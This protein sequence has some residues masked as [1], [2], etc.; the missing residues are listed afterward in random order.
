M[1]IQTNIDPMV[2][3]IYQGIGSGGGK[4][5]IIEETVDFAGSE[6]L[7]N[8]EEYEAGKD[9]QMYPMLAGAVVV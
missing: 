6:S 2:A 4:K 5:A 9:L 3:I 8:A 7:L 1:P